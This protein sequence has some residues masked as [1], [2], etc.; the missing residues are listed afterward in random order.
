MSEF[1]NPYAMG[2]DKWQETVDN[3]FPD[4]ELPTQT[5]EDSNW[6]EFVRDLFELNPEIEQVRS[7]G[8]N[9][10]Q[11]WAEQQMALLIS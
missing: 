2:F 6:R 8:F 11:E 10:W 9:S 4:I 5:Y 7:E 1:V 3:I